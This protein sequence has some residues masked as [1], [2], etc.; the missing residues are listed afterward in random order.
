VP[1]E[2]IE[3]DGCGVRR[4]GVAVVDPYSVT[5]DEA[6]DLSLKAAYGTPDSRREWHRAVPYL[7]SSGTAGVTVDPQVVILTTQG[8]Y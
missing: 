6:S 3:A 8:G 5:A 4:G 2:P 7:S 1:P